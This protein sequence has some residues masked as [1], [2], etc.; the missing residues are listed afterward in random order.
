MHHD[1]LHPS[2]GIGGDAQCSASAADVAIAQV[3]AA[4]TVFDVVGL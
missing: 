2:L 4:G 3:A 1:V